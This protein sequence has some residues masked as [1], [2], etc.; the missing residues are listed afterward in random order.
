MPMAEQRIVFNGKQ[1][2]DSDALGACGVEDD[3]TLSV[4]A[5]LLGGAKKRKVGSAWLNHV[6]VG[7]DVQ[8][9]CLPLLDC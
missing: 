5:R 9:T 6:R 3:A 7:A 2:E 8:S 1:L 4:L